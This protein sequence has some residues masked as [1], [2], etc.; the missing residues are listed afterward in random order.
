MVVH[1]GWTGVNDILSGPNNFIE[2]YNPKA[3]PAALIDQLG[4]RYEVTLTTLKK[5]TTGGPIQAPLDALDNMRKK[6]PFEADQVK[7]VVVRAA[8]SAAYTVN[9][10]DM[11]DICLQHLVAI[12]LLD[13]TVSFRTA[14]D[15]ARMQD[16]AVLA[17]RA[18]VQLVPDESLEKLIPVRVAI[19]EV[20]LNDGT[21]LSERVDA[22]RGTP[23]NPMPRKE[24]MVKA[25]DLM[26]PV[27]G[28]AACSKLIERMLELDKVKDIRQLRPL[29]QRG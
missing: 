2:S 24:V 15:K 26:E 25:R 28:A 10:R 17:E 18:K 8:T 13:K 3:D 22:V 11:P 27:L 4:E 9:D 21:R 6:H 12:M 29:L 7:K 19:V 23:D 1:S 16:P 5:W 14:H 20:T